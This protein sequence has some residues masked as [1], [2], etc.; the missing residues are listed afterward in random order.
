MYTILSPIS[1]LLIVTIRNKESA[2]KIKLKN[3][4]NKK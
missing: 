3:E 2:I 4:T 1:N